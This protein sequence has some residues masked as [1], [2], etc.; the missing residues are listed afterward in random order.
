MHAPYLQHKIE[1]HCANKR[2]FPTS[3][4]GSLLRAKVKFI[5][6]IIRGTVRNSRRLKKVYKYKMY[7]MMYIICRQQTIVIKLYYIVTIEREVTEMNLN[8]II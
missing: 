2:L 6:H 8:N 4:Y 1:I 5:H 7:V 3:Q